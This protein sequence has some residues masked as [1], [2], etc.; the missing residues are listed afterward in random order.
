MDK[1]DETCPIC[2]EPLS[3][4][5]VLRFPNCAHRFHT[6]CALLWAHSD[7]RCPVCRQ[8]PDQLRV[9][10]DAAADEV[11]NL[12]LAWDSYFRQRNR[13]LRQRPE[14]RKL[15]RRVRAIRQEMNREVAVLRRT[16][17]RRCRE[18]WQRDA[19]V[20]EI[21]RRITNLRRRELRV[22]RLLEGHEPWYE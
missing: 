7:L 8:Q 14:V 6:H 19:Q 9:F 11:G 5:D 15:Y 4:E 21:R 13:Y 2:L 10:E 3:S 1:T 12:V 17:K 20:K 22:E 16:Y 18:I